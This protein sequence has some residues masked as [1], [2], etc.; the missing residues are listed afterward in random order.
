M[1][2]LYRINQIDFH[3]TNTKTD[4]EFLT[5]FKAFK[6]SSFIKEIDFM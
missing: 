5:M 2:S 3:C 6:S 1:Q 4:G